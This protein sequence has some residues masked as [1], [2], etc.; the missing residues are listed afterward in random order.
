MELA[1]YCLSRALESFALCLV[2]WGVIRRRDVP[3]RID[4]FMFRLLNLHITPC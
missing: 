1:I 2:E 3:K 4:V